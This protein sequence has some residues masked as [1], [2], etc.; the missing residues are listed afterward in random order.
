MSNSMINTNRVQGFRQP[1][2]PAVITRVISRASN[3][4]N[5]YSIDVLRISLGLVFLAFGVQKFF[6]GISPAEDLAVATIEKL[7]FGV[8]SGG[9]A[10][11]MTAIMECIIGVTMVTGQLVRVGL[12]M[13]AVAVIGIMSPLVIF[14]PAMFPA[15]GPTLEAQYVFKDIVLATAGLVV[16]A[17]SLGGRLVSGQRVYRRAA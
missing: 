12:V 14:F 16:A 7:T 11:L 10:L 8:I 13:L 4:L 15:G 5:R 17:K 3:L 9:G 2:P 1:E 6:P